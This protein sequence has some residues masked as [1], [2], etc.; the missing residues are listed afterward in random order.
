[1]ITLPQPIVDRCIRHADLIVRN[2]ESLYHPSL[3]ASLAVSSHGAQLNVKLQAHAKM[4]ECAFCIWADLP[5]DEALNWSGLPDDGA[6][7]A[8]DSWQ[9]DVKATTARG[10]LLIWP[11]YKKQCYDRKHFNALVLVKG[12]VP[13][14][15]VQGFIEKDRFSQERITAAASDRLT[16]GTW[17]V[18][19][20]TL[21][22]PTWLLPPD[23]IGGV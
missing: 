10:R 5:I 17:F 22:H 18:D 2:Y 12:D 7:V 9:V 8:I 15:R 14:F 21:Y 11:V 6:D 19:E 16:P 13:D 1:M 20:T 3:K 4:A 23:Q